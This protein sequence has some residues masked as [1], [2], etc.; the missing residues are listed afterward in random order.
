VPGIVMMLTYY[1][2]FMLLLSELLLARADKA[3]TFQNKFSKNSPRKYPLFCR[4]F[5]FE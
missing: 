5:L 3:L 1:L 2:L 4:E